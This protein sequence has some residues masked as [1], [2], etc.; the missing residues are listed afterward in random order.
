MEHKNSTLQTTLL[1]EVSTQ[2]LHEIKG[3]YNPWLD[4]D[5]ENEGD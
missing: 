5:Q 4:D 2:E 3:G 1:K